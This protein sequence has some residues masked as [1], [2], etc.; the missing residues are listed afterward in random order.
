M[1]K[2]NLNLGVSRSGSSHSLN[3]VSSAFYGLQVGESRSPSVKHVV[4]DEKKPMNAAMA[5]FRKKEGKSY[6][7]KEASHASSLGSTSSLDDKPPGS[8]SSRKS[9]KK[10]PIQSPETVK[11]KKSMFEQRLM[12]I[13]HS[14]G[15][16]QPHL[17]SLP[18]ERLGDLK[19]FKK[20][21]NII[22]KYRMR[23]FN[24]TSTI[25]LEST[26][27]NSDAEEYLK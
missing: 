17:E 18:I 10:K 19:D 13:S 14:S 23:K 25:F 2:L 11:R 5:A 1:E 26:I 15:D 22:Q 9:F 16:A 3:D 7:H 20:R 21:K 4:V 12:E 27:V 8:V 6:V 24:S